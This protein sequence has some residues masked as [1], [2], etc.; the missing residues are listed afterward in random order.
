MGRG[1]VGA[2]M[3]VLQSGGGHHKDRRRSTGEEGGSEI[4][5]FIIETWQAISHCCYSIVW[6][7]MSKYE[8]GIFKYKVLLFIFSDSGRP[9][10]KRTLVGQIM[11]VRK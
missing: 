1:S 5:L 4:Y 11:S 6:L 2:W 3:E 8:C 7:Y 10:F 9:L